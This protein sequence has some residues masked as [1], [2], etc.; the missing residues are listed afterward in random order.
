MRLSFDLTGAALRLFCLTRWTA[1]A[2]SFE[3]VLHNCEALLKTL[4]SI[5]VVNDGVTCLEITTK[6]SGIHAHLETFDLFSARVVFIKF[7]H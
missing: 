7:I 3:S 5:S 6:A 2:K 4:L 1:K